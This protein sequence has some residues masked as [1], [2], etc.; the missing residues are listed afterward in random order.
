MQQLLLR[1]SGIHCEGCEERIARA[2]RELG[3]G[4]AK[5]VAEHQAGTVR[6]VFDPARTSEKS[7]RAAI[8]RAGYQITP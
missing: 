4:I 3:S 2:E 8:E 6:I 7:V 1:V 5:V